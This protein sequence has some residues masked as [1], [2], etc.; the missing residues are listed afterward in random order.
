MTRISRREFVALATA[1]AA[2]A[3]FVSTHNARA[4]A[5]TAQEI[6]D[7]IKRNVGVDWKGETVDTFKAGDPAS[8][9]TGVVT[10]ALPTLSVLKQAVK[11]GANVVITCEPTFYS[12]ADR[13]TPPPRRGGAPDDPAPASSPDRVFAAKRDFIE[14]NGLVVWRFS[15]HWRLRRPD[16]F[17]KGLID[18]LG[19]SGSTSADEP[20]RVSIRGISLGTL[21][22]QAKKR[23]NAR[24]GIRV[25]GHPRMSVQ[26]IGVLPGSTP[27]QAALTVLPG[28]D[29]VIAGEVREWESVEYARDTLAAG[30]KKGLILLGRVL[31]EEPGMHVCAQWI[32]TLVPELTT[33]WIPAGDPYWR[34]R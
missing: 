31:S 29:A 2:G 10:S 7:R 18:A 15:D 4:A 25:V 34:P 27:I 33:T 28:V 32:K 1:G 24:G 16:P 20:T 3:P 30:S 26:T 13:P 14:K 8:V 5:V 11:A 9:A 6:V 21:A 19:W 12:R 23:L 17:A 22:S